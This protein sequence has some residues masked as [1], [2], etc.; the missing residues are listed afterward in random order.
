LA[1][2]K[3]LKHVLELAYPW[4]EPATGLNLGALA[5]PPAIYRVMP[6]NAAMTLARGLESME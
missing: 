3:S 6:C 2:R 5:P 4:K 1:Q